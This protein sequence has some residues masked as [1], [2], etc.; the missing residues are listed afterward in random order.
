MTLETILLLF[1]LWLAMLALR[2]LWRVADPLADALTSWL[3][4]AARWAD[5]K[6]HQRSVIEELER[7]R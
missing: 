5:G 1:Y 6:H 3:R 2:I 7:G 4:M